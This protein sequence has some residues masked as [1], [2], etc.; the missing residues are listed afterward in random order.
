MVISYLL[1]YKRSRVS[2]GERPLNFSSNASPVDPRTSITAILHAIES[3]RARHERLAL[4]GRAASAAAPDAHRTELRGPTNR[5]RLR[6][7]AS[8]ARIQRC[9]PRG[10][11]G[12][13]CASWKNGRESAKG[14][15]SSRCSLGQKENFAISRLKTKSTARRF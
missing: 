13:S 14:R 5:A 8:G 2:P 3:V 15:E 9:E 12:R 4:W 1:V 11:R 7:H 6:R 10:R